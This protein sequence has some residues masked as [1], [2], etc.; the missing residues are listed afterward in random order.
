MSSS[1]VPLYMAHVPGTANLVYA[2][3]LFDLAALPQAWWPADAEPPDPVASM[4]GWQSALPY[5]AL[6]GQL[7]GR[8]STRQ[9][10]YAELATQVARRGEWE[11]GEGEGDTGRADAPA[12]VAITLP[13]L[14]LR[15]SDDGCARA[16]VCSC[17][18]TCAR[19]P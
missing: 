13:F 17:S 14:D 11:G 8:M 18:L 12:G 10:G 4:P 7:L 9:R 15:L 2:R 3:L 19:A 16:L 1:P 6:M 5:V